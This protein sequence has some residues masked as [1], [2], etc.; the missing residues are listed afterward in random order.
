MEVKCSLLN[1]FFQMLFIL[2][3]EMLPVRQDTWSPTPMGQPLTD[4]L[5]VFVPPRL[6]Q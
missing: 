5:E 4:L 2:V 6:N 3:C 1:L